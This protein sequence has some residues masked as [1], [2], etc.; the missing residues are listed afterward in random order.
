MKTPKSDR[1][2]VLVE[3]PNGVQPASISRA[4]WDRFERVRAEHEDKVLERAR[5]EWERMFSRVSGWK[6]PVEVAGGEI[7]WV[8]VEEE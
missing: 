4:E 3:G 6:A 5:V 1:V 2:P 7:K 8:A